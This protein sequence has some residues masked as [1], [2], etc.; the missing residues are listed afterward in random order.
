MTLFRSKTLENFNFTR[1]LAKKKRI[2]WNMSVHN[3]MNGDL[4]KTD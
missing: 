4:F 1:L 2:I 3:E